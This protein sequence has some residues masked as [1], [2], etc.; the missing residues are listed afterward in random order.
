VIKPDH[1]DILTKKKIVMNDS[2]YIS[3][4]EAAQLLGVSVVTISRWEKPI[5]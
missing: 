2:N 1:F 4:G 3:I 5:S